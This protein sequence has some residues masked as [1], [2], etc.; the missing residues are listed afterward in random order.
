MTEFCLPAPFAVGT[1]GA[2]MDTGLHDPTSQPI[3]CT[4]C[5]RPLGLFPEDQPDWATGPICGECYQELNFE[6][7]VAFGMLYEEDDATPW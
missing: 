7:E 6:D 3:Y 4:A 2:H 1:I 5:G